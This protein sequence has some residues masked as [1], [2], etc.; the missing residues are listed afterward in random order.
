MR[1][2]GINL[3]VAVVTVL[4]H[5]ADSWNWQVATKR[6]NGFANACG[7]SSCQPAIGFARLTVLEGNTKALQQ[8]FASIAEG[9]CFSLICFL[10][11]TFLKAFKII[12]SKAAVVP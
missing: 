1:F 7:A 12:L 9:S 2:V 8:A 10:Q 3:Q 4:K 5:Q 11:D 6:Q